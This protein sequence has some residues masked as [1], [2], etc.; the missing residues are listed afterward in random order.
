[1]KIMVSWSGGKDSAWML[2]VIRRQLPQ[3]E[4][5]G[6]VTTLNECFDRIAMHGVR[7]ELLEA[8]AESAGVPLWTVPLPWPCTNETYEARM[9]NLITKAKEL[10]VE[11]CAFGDLFLTEI[12]AYRERQLAGTGIDPIFPI[13]GIP[14]KDLAQEMIRSGMRARLSCVDPKQISAEFAGREFDEKLLAE[15]PATADPCGEN[16]EFHSFVYAGPMLE[17]NI[18]VIN[19]ETVTRDG[20]VYTDF[21]LAKGSTSPN[22]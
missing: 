19:G 18:P 15:L 10:G 6:L 20:F 22:A 13:W 8:Q 4:I 21:M 2:H 12:R 11:A 1:M 5:A 17:R 7:R 14:T 9:R 16:G 3:A